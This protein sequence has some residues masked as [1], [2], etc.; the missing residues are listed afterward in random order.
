MRTPELL[1]GL[2]GGGP[3]FVFPLQLAA[4]KPL[5]SSPKKMETRSVWPICLHGR[6][7]GS[8]LSQYRSK[9]FCESNY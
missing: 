8:A 7:S 6:E 1:K 2:L 4:A 3:S 9:S 5:L